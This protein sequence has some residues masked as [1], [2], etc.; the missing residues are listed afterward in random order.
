MFCPVY[1][2]GVIFLCGSANVFK[3]CCFAG[4]CGGA[5]LSRRPSSWWS[6]HVCVSIKD[7]SVQWLKIF[8]LRVTETQSEVQLWPVNYSVCRSLF[9]PQCKSLFYN[10]TGVNGAALHHYRLPLNRNKTFVSPC[11]QGESLLYLDVSTVLPAPC[12]GCFL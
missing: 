5:R 11:W 3:D 12:L 4:V 10:H 9:A 1:R 8:C 7:I 6:Q 2:N